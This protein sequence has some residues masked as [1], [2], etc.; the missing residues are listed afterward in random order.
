MLIQRM[1]SISR[2]SP[3]MLTSNSPTVRLSKR[4]KTCAS[5]NWTPRND[6]RAWKTPLRVGCDSGGL[7]EGS[8]PGRLAVD[9]PAHERLHSAMF[10]GRKGWIAPRLPAVRVD[11]GSSG[12]GLETSRT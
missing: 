7:L 4:N 1:S 5:Q 10:P 12:K 9:Y 2:N 11:P 3:R 8:S 6:L